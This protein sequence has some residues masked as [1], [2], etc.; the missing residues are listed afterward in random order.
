MWEEW[1]VTG[2]M[3][4]HSVSIFVQYCELETVTSM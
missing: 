3:Q 1:P 2:R 4:L